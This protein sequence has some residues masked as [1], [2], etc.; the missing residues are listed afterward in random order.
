MN[1]RIRRGLL[2][3]LA[4][5]C[6]LFPLAGCRRQEGSPAPETSAQPQRP[7]TET[8]AETDPPETENREDAMTQEPEKPAEPKFTDW[9][10]T[11]EAANERA[12]G[13]QGRFTDAGRNKFLVT[14]GSMSLLY[15]LT[16]NGSKGVEAIGNAEGQPYFEH[17]MDAY[18]LLPD[19]TRCSASR[20]PKNGRMNSHR[21]GYYY[22]DFRFCDQ[23][24]VK[25]DAEGGAG[26]DFYDILANA[27]AWNVNDTSPVK[28]KD[29][30][31]SYKVTS[32]YDPY[33]FAG[34]HYS[35]E[36]Y[37]AVEMTIRTE[38][39]SAGEFYLVAG[40]CESY[41]ADQRTSFQVTPGEWTTVVVPLTVIPDYTGWVK[42][43]RID[44]GAEKDEAVE[45]R[46]LRAVKIGSASVPFALERIFHTYSDKVHEVLRAV[47]T[48]RYDGGGRFE[49][50]TAIP[51][52]TVAGILLKNASG[53]SG[54]LDGFDFTTAEFVGFDIRGVGVYGV[55]LP[56]AKDNGDIRVSLRDGM[57]VVTRGIDLK[58][59]IRKG[60]DVLFGQRL[61]TSADHDF[62]GLRRE[63][64]IERTPLGSVRITAASDGAKYKGYDALAGCY[65]FALNGSDFNR[66]YYQEPDKHFAVH[67]EIEG[68]GGADR[69]VYVQVSCA[70]YGCLES[71]ALLDEN[72]VMLPLPIEVSKNF[73]GEIEEPLFDPEDPAY[74]EAYFP[75]TIGG[76]EVK[77]FT[78][79][80]LYQNWG[81]YPLKQLSSIAFHIPYYHLSVG[82]TE[83]NCIAPYFVFAK[84]GWTLPD[85]RANSAPFWST[86]PQHTSAGRLYFLQ[87]RDAD[88]R[89][90][91]S[92]S[93]HAEIASA[94]P[95]YADIAM[96]YLSDDGRIR[97]SYRHAETAQTDETRTYYTITL[98]VL[99]PV[100]IAD[101]RRDFSFFTFDG[102]SVYYKKMGWLNETGRSVT[103][104][105]HR[106][107]RIIML[108]REYPY[109]DY[110]G[111]NVT[112]S[113]NFALIVRRADIT[114]G[115][116]PFDGGFVLYDRAD[117]S[118]NRGS[119]SLDLGEVTL[120]PGDR[121]EIE[122]ILLPWGYSTS[123]DDANV[124]A[125]REDSCLDPYCLT[126]LEGEPVEDC[127]I[128]SV[129]AKDGRASFRLTGGRNT[130][131]VRVYGFDSYAPPR[132]SF[133]ADGKDTDIA[134][135]GPNGYDGYQ[136]YRDADGTYSFSFNVDMDR[137]GE[138]EITVEGP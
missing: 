80:H 21:L 31:I 39:A 121:M 98:D 119:L 41:T 45:V 88:G 130:A 97:A 52:D 28:K 63:A 15:D 76:N 11:I 42:G 1:G 56:D 65:R 109:Y 44:C 94:G 40:S 132:V 54:T 27:G 57:Y 81:N 37:D 34:V 117:G 74:G 96:D 104:D 108:G 14:N 106:G 24:F 35:A 69:T 101:F 124:R 135:A 8:P 110:F 114:I 75:L 7:E 137:A 50:E 136:V 49:T 107:E 113:V 127:F 22:Y 138:W 78:V 4:A 30:G 125:V 73:C 120:L 48:N 36:E 23:L 66:A 62:D 91:L 131:A 33:I 58:A 100:K 102:R 59:S 128:P 123:A 17:T 47:A 5:L 64:A 89:A 83:S 95:V 38:R 2:G 77:R 72:N 19:G 118:L 79:L 90:N 46:T 82:T 87:Y 29:G 51:A 86:Q 55:I 93:Q 126:V 61:Y 43:F 10:G 122:M 111:G 67:A 99:E 112:D 25:A 60:G 13:V 116:K 18:F 71:A 105:V 68:D 103:S 134:L 115:G 3:G 92:E 12:N 32:S 133:R 85:F 84:D 20:S 26:E 9:P 129:R 53:E 16:G 70:P 6:L